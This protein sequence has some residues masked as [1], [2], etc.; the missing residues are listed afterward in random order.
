MK[1]LRIDASARLND[2]ITRQLADEL[3]GHLR[4][5]HAELEMT[6]RELSNG[7]P[8]LDETWVGANFTPAEQRSAEQN[9]ALNLSHVLIEELKAADAMVLAVPIY[10]FGVPAVMKAWIDL[11]TRAKVTFRYTEQGAEGL[12]RDRPVYLVM[13]SGGTPVDSDMDFAARYL[14]FILNFIGIRDIRMIAA[15]QMNVDPDN[16]LQRARAHM[17]EAMNSPR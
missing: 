7:L 17:V 3:I 6:Q 12:L 11:I 8:L 13:A 9:Q 14:R 16:A 15:D 1:L 5:R 10:N 2:S 4:E